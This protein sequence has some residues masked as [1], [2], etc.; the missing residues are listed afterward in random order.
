MND[1]G[2]YECEAVFS[3]DGQSSTKTSVAY[4]TVYGQ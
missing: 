1:V 2:Q 3:N 4:I